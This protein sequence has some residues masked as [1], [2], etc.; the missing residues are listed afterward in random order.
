MNFL[1][2]AYLSFNHDDILIGNMISDFVKGKQKDNYPEGIKKG[3]MLHRQIDTF[4]DMHPV[5]MEAKKV[6]KPLVRLY[7]GA[8]VDVAF[9]YFIANDEEQKTEKEWKIFAQD[10]YGILEKY[11]PYFPAKFAQLFPHMRQY[12]WLYNYRFA[13]E[14]KNSFNNVIRRAK[15]LS[16]DGNL[17][18]A[19]FEENIPLLK[20]CYDDFFPKLKAFVLREL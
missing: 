18:F 19:A 6:F 10:T 4:T 15:Y 1:A 16:I 7:A 17:V 3:I 11:R 9:D 2:H 8:F 5:V 12:D 13:W 20:E 14:M